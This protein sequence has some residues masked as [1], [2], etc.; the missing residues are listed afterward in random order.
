MPAKNIASVLNN[1]SNL[2]ILEKLK[3]RPYY[4]RELAGEMGLSEPFIVRRLKAME[5]HDIVEG[6]WETEGSRKVKRY[7]VK[8][9]TLQLGKDGLKV[10]TSEVQA[11]QDINIFKELAGTLTRLPLILVLVCGVIFN[12]WYL[13]AIVA[14]IFVWNAAIDYAFY[15]DFRLKT[16]LLSMV[17][18]M[19]V[20]L[21]LMGI[22]AVSGIS[23]V[24]AEIA[25]TAM[26]IGLA[27]LVLV[28]VYRSRFYQLEYSE[29]IEDMVGLMAR[30]EEA[31]LYVKAFY[32]PTAIR[33]KINE[34]FGLI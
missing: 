20:A 25:A 29:L 34:Y 17:V 4:P 30:L 28:V 23:S 14:I 2:R 9:V 27:V 19:A 33:W 32:L 3:V 16:P 7:Y 8:D 1:E 6:R 22:I 26:V 5:E 15:K 11:K 31:P 18:N 21:L 24:P 12:I 13:M 10:T